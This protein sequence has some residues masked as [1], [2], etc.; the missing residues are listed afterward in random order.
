MESSKKLIE[1]RLHSCEKNYEIVYKCLYECE[2]AKCTISLNSNGSWINWNS[3]TTKTMNEL[4]KI[5]E[6]PS[7]L[8]PLQNDQVVEDDT[9]K[10][11]KPT[12]VAAA[13]HVIPTRR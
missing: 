6:M 13:E 2:K 1:K 8:I 3:I 12:L 10:P 11:K 5:I 4:L 7:K 9:P